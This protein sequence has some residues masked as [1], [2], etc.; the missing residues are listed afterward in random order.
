MFSSRTLLVALSLVGAL[1]VPRRAHASSDDVSDVLAYERAVCAAYE[2]NDATAIDSLVADDYVLT[3]SSGALTK[4]ADDLRDAR[5]KA[6]NFTAFRNEEMQVT[7]Y[8]GTAIV[9]GKTI[10][11][12]TTKDG[13]KVDVLV[14]F[15]DT[16]VK[17]KGRWKLVA[18][19][20]SRLKNG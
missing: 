18:G 13:S 20:V 4:K 19:H 8:G 10:V 1:V 15:T 14:R 7:M 17:I 9:R 3:E 16:I 5:S 11:Q 12:G 6:V 2:R